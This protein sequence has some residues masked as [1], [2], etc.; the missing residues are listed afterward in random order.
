MRSNR[1]GRRRPSWILVVFGGC[2]IFVCSFIVFEVLDVD[3]SDFPPA[4]KSLTA[5]TAI[6]SP[7]DAKRLPLQK[8]FVLHALDTVSA[9]APAHPIAFVVWRSRGSGETLRALRF[10]QLRVCPIT[11]A[12][13]S[14]PA[15]GPA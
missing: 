2:L 8:R 10:A 4:T 11:L 12:R 14:L 1:L 7:H 13:S 5:L 15:P 3:G 9:W 6:E